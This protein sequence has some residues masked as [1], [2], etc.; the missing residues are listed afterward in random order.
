VPAA[1]RHLIVYQNS[2]ASQLIFDEVDEWEAFAHLRQRLELEGT[3]YAIA[4]N[5]CQVNVLGTALVGF[6]LA[7]SFFL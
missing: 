2:N 7:G 5:G 1:D 6:D 3:Q 4:L